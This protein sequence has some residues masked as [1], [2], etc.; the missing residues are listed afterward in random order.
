MS[1]QQQIQ[2]KLEAA[3]QPVFLSVENESHMHNVPPGSESHFKIT[4]AAESF[5]GLSL[6][7]RHR[8]VN[9]TLADELNGQIHALALHTLTPDQWFERSGNVPDSPECLGGGK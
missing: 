9:A 8:Q 1:M 7:Q 2:E 3:F 6:I 5:E 4:L